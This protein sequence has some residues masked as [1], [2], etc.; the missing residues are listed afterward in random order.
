MT[1]R[2]KIELRREGVVKY[3]Q[4]RGYGNKAQQDV[5]AELFPLPKVTR[6]RTIGSDAGWNYQIRDGELVATV[7]NGT[8][9]RELFLPK[10]ADL[11]K[12]IESP[13]EEVDSE[14]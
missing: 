8:Y 9:R 6:P 1:E 4:S 12:L 2:E 11:K 13:T 5:A 10:L 3:L 7:G 14:C